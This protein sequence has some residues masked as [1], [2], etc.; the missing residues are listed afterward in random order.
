MLVK[1]SLV[2]WNLHKILG[3]GVRATSHCLELHS[4]QLHVLWHTPLHH[5]PCKPQLIILL[6]YLLSCDLKYK[7]LK[8]LN[9]RWFLKNMYKPPQYESDHKST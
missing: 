1:L 6:V 2:I 8:E 7:Y 9:R 5:I 3:K 4:I